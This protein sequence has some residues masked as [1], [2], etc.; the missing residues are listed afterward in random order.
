VA[1]D[2]EAWAETPAW[3]AEQRAD[4]VPVEV[5]S[6]VDVRRLAP[7]IAP[8]ALGGVFGAIDGQA[9]AMPTVQAFAAAARRLGARVEEGAGVASITREHGR[10]AGVVRSDGRREPC[11]VA[12]ATVG[13]WTPTLLR[14]LDVRIPVT[15]RPLQMLL[16]TPA[17]M[18]LR[19]VLS[20]FGRRLSFKQL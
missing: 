8:G 11:D 6:A 18:A 20:A 5:M 10:V 15:T 2:A 17:P 1:L 3:V 7:E 12:I 14:G 13:A 19:P 16:T 9:E 4:N